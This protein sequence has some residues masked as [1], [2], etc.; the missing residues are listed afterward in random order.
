MALS[1]MGKKGR[2]MA[3]WLGGYLIQ[4]MYPYSVLKKS[5]KDLLKIHLIK[6]AQRDTGNILIT[7]K[8]Q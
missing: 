8:E 6:S 1:P 3:A 7:I 5:A 4:K 2:E